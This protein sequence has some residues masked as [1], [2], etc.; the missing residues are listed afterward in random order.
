MK[1]VFKAGQLHISLRSLRAMPSVGWMNLGWAEA[2]CAMHPSPGATMTVLRARWKVG[3]TS[4][5]RQRDT[6][7]G[8][9]RTSAGREWGVTTAA[10]GR[11]TGLRTREQSPTPSQFSSTRC[12]CGVLSLFGVQGPSSC[13]LLLS[14]SGPGGQAHGTPTYWNACANSKV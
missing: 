8:R 2:H 14:S 9:R 12:P 6:S 3:P 11:E 5:T 10:A 7:D 1:W 13:R 4:Q